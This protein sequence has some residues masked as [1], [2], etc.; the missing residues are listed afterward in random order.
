MPEE[1]EDPRPDH[2]MEAGT[3]ARETQG[4]AVA[5]DEV[6]VV[7]PSPA[8]SRCSDW[9]HA[10]KAVAEALLTFFGLNPLPTFPYKELKEPIPGIA[11]FLSSY[12]VFIPYV[13]MFTKPGWVVQYFKGVVDPNTRISTIETIF[14][15]VIAGLTVGLVI[16]PQGLSYATLALLPPVNGLYAAILPSAVY[17]FFGCSMQLAVGPVAISSLLTGSLVSKYGI[18]YVTQPDQAVDLA[19]QAAMA[20]GIILVAM[21]V[22]NLGSLIRF[23]S[24][25]V[26][27]GFTT[28]AAC[29]IGLSQL[30]SAFGFI[31]KAPQQGDANTEWNYQVMK[32]F[33]QNWN[34]TLTYNGQTYQ[35]RNPVTT[36]IFIGIY[37]PLAIIQ[38][39]KSLIAATPER[40][41]QLWF[42]VW[43]LFANLSPFIGIVIAGKVA[44]DIISAHYSHGVFDDYYVSKLVIVGAITPGVNIIRIPTFNYP[45]NTLFVDVLPLTFV[46]FMESYSVANKLATLNKQLHFLSSSQEL[47]AVG[48]ANIIG[49][50]GSAYPVAG[51]YSRSSLN[52]AVGAKSPLS[53]ITTICVVLVCLGIA[54]TALYFIPKCALAAVIWVALYNILAFTEWW[55]AYQTSVKDFFVMIITFTMVFVFDSAV[56]LAVGLGASLLVYLFE[57]VFSG[58]N[59]PISKEVGK[60]GLKI[61]LVR[62]NNDLNFLTIYRIKDFI[63][64]DVLMREEPPHALIIDFVDVKHI[65]LTCIKAFEEIKAECEEK[66]VLFITTNVIPPVQEEME[67]L[68]IF[69]DSEQID[70]GIGEEDEAEMK[71][72]AISSSPS[73]QDLKRGFHELQDIPQ[74]TVHKVNSSSELQQRFA[75]MR[76]LRAQLPHDDFD[77]QV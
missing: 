31:V 21:S 76:D 58:R 74:Q 68:G 75:N 36:N 27:S 16:I 67:K 29:L 19:A 17:S 50:V 32:W 20:M 7:T 38:R 30:S 13:P 48:M 44:Y 69:G 72:D 15:D 39:L 41:K 62:L 57:Y 55:E 3:Y 47:W 42:R 77:F 14:N 5:A 26:L 51:S 49:S 8:K 35:Y 46:T 71:N 53:A 37:V 61:E 40:K 4:N 65:D 63:S 33:H 6:E 18:N 59:R 24:F 34:G 52:G 60:N 25:P 70:V 64:F 11:H 56:G 9:N 10:S 66:N 12:R 54:T 1:G 45:W 43:T 22:L 23:I 28:A 2:D 73:L